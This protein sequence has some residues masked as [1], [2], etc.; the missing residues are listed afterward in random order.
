MKPTPQVQVC[1]TPSD[2]QMDLWPLPSASC[3]LLLEGRIIEKMTSAPAL[4]QARLR[5]SAVPRCSRISGFLMSETPWGGWWP[6]ATH[7]SWEAHDVISEAAADALGEQWK[8][9]TV[10]ISGVNNKQ[11]F[12]VKQDVWPHGRGACYWL[13]KEYSCYK[14]QRI[15]ETKC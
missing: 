4:L 10:Q 12:P 14:L 15:R 7:M 1:H 2:S 3:P 5:P 13:T 11:G 9:D 8:G 6:Q